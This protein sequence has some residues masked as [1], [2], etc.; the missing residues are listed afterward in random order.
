VA[1]AHR[2]HVLHRDLKPSNILVTEDRMVKLLDFGISKLLDGQPGVEATL[3]MG[4]PQILTP[5]YASPEQVR[6]EPMTESSD[7]YS[8]GV[9]LYELVADRRPYE[10]KT[11][12]PQE[13][14]LMVCER[15]PP[16]PS[17]ASLCS[18]L[19]GDLDS[20]VGMALRKEA[21]FRYPSVE[22][23]AADL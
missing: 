8:L 19:T 21:P 4:S 11:R 15:E 7:V 16:K 5:E 22:E 10:F 9:L 18:E 2:N 17:S 14:V 12:S 1:Y 13:I 20:I 6:G 23:L 3:T